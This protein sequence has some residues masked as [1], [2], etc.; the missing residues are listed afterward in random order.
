[1]LYIS[2]IFI[3]ASHIA[4]IYFFYLSP[5]ALRFSSLPLPCWRG[6]LRH[7]GA[8]PGIHKGGGASS[9]NNWKNKMS[10]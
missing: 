1:M 3:L 9:E 6:K 4:Q 5:T 7:A 8:C 2:W 10:D